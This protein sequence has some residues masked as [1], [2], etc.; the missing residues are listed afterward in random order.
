MREQALLLVALTALRMNPSISSK[1]LTNCGV[2]TYWARG[3]T[4]SVT[5]FGGVEDE[6]AFAHPFGQIENL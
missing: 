3:F 6:V 1:Q 5:P 4:G 2:T